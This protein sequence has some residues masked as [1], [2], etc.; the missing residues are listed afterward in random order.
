LPIKI[1]LLSGY[2]TLNA[3]SLVLCTDTVKPCSV[4]TWFN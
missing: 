3:I 4:I 1:L 2:C